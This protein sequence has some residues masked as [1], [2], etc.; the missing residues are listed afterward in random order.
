M[1]RPGSLGPEAT[2]V[3][4]SGLTNK[5]LRSGPCLLH[6]CHSHHLL[7]WAQWA[8]EYLPLC[9]RI[10]SLFCPGRW[11]RVV[12]TKLS[13][14]PNHPPGRN[15]GLSN[16]PPRCLGVELA[17][18]PFRPKML[19]GSAVPSAADSQIPHHPNHV[20]P[21]NLTVMLMP[22]QRKGGESAGAEQE[23]PSK[24][25]PISPFTSLHAIGISLAYALNRIPSA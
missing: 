6:N 23:T 5:R 4:L 19:Y 20:L 12:A 21:T 1:S 8:V 2:A 15:I 9:V 17:M 13:Y 10:H 22:G 25:R 24:T 3:R 18:P 11:T 14:Q 16:K 7:L